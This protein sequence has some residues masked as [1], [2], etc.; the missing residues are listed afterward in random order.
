MNYYITGCI[1]FAGLSSLYLLNKYVK[2]KPTVPVLKQESNRYAVVNLTP[3]SINLYDESNNLLFKIKAEKPDRQLRISSSQ[4]PD[5]DE[6]YTIISSEYEYDRESLDKD[7]MK[8]RKIWT[9]YH[10]TDC[11]NYISGLIPVKKPVKYDTLD[12]AVELRNHLK[13]YHG[14]YAIIV[15][16]MVA[17]FMINHKKE[18]MDLNVKILVPNSDPKNSV[19]DSNGMIIGVKGFI[20][21]GELSKN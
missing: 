13:Y 20:D 12:G 5:T 19:R 7:F 6:M 17:E 10:D 14:P 18:F 3:H 11:T 21:Y 9:Y 1:G 16:M 2:T 4:Q 8:D 15:S